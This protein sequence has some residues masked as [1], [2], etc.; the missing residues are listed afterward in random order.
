M[1]THCVPFPVRAAE[2]FPYWDGLLPVRI[3]TSHHSRSDLK[4]GRGRLPE[5]HDFALRG[6]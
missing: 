4:G 2:I 5:A 1:G 3:V 6:A